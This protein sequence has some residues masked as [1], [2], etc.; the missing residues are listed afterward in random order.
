MFLAMIIALFEQGGDIGPS[1]ASCQLRAPAG[2]FENGSRAQPSAQRRISESDSFGAGTTRSWA[3]T[4]R[5][6][7]ALIFGQAGVDQRR[8]AR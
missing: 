4:S 1:P 8:M 2:K 3:T 6:D 7:A 5:A